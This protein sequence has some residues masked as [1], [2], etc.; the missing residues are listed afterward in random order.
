MRGRSLDLA[1]RDAGAPTFCLLTFLLLVASPVFAVPDLK[2]DVLT[3]CCNCGDIC[4][5][6]FDHLNFPHTNG[7]YIAMGTDTHRYAL[8]TNGNA[9]A[10]YYNTLNDGWTTNSG[11]VSAS[12]INYYAVSRFTATGARPNWVVL[13]EI[14]SG[15]W[16]SDSSYRAWVR[17]VVHALKTAYGFNVVLYSPFPN[18]GANA[19][20]WQ[21][22]AA[23][24]CI[25]IENYLSGS[26]VAGQAFSVS[27]CQGQYQ[28]SINSYTSLGVPR[29]KLM[30]GE[31]F[32][33]TLAGTSYGRAGVSSNDW[34]KVIV[35]RNQGAQNVGF[36]GFLSYAWGGNAMGITEDEQLEH[37]DTYRSN[38][39]P[40][41]NGVT[42]PS[43]VI[44]PQNQTLPEGSD[45]GF[46]VFKSGTAPTTYQWRFNGAS[47]S[48]A[49]NWT[50]NLTNVQANQ[51]GNYSVVLSNATGSVTSSNAFLAVQVPD[52]WAFE[53]FA[54]ATSTYS[55]AANL[56]GQTNAAGQ[57]WTQAGPS[58]VQPTIQG[59]NL[60]AGGL[61]GP[62]GN[63]VKFGG[64]GMSARFNL[65]TNGSSG[66]WYYS[67][68][69]RLTD[70]STLNANGVFW[71]GFN[72]S[73][74]TQ[75][76]TPNVVDTRLVT[77]SA[78]GGF[79]IGLDK[80]SGTAPNF[81]FVPPAFSTNDTLFV[82]ASYTFNSAATNDDVSQ[83]WV[84]PPPASFGLA[85]APPADLTNSA[86][87]DISA[88][89]SFVLFNR[90]ANEP[91]GIIA[92]EIRIGQSW[93]SVTPPAE[94]PVV[95]NLSI[96]RT[97]LTNVL[98][99]TTNAPG[100]VLESASALASP[101][102]WSPVASPIF[103]GFDQFL[104]TNTGTAGA[105]FFRLRLPQ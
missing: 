27:Y 102:A 23:D 105:V 74:G 67:M 64:N 83:M 46:I 50:L 9:L 88:I 36:A 45:V 29:A 79:N 10:V 43:L 73:A 72:N 77:R 92:D 99:W 30:L 22:V 18:P 38:N 5:N 21:A 69:V 40:V 26:E 103:I 25:G 20:D 33:Q 97:G 12:N 94:P 61:A 28:S 95:P 75:T 59:G 71:A 47:L 6:E 37:E 56:I 85:A 87:G 24:A 31:H 4:T 81:V 63:S 3:F 98:S 78:T 51:S 48:G 15:L 90:N 32:S 13:N 57:Y 16:P 44:Q 104:V 91:A 93:A 89:A 49:T 17:D 35:A 19:V 65:R 55:P 82:V 54:P 58:G 70:I 39:L 52:P 80:S 8:A 14:S 42:A 2:F 60:A 11:S 62:S 96:S 34:D 53:P 86:G 7:H 41:N 1:G 101:S 68:L 84:N 66:T 76:T 100:Y